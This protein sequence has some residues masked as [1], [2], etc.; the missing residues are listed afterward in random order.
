M[1]PAEEAESLKISIYHVLFLIL[2]QAYQIMPPQLVLPHLIV[3][4]DYSNGTVPKYGCFNRLCPGMQVHTSL[5]RL[6]SKMMSSSLPDVKSFL[7]WALALH[8]A[9]TQYIHHN[10]EDR[11]K[12]EGVKG[13]VKYRTRTKSTSL[14]S[15]TCSLRNSAVPW[16][17]QGAGTPQSPDKAKAI[18]CKHTVAI[19]NKGFS[20]LY[21]SIFLSVTA[22]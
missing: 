10:K 3:N 21:K 2:F 18:P 15:F 17:E 22:V 19:Q 20:L 11:N 1:P 8:Q 14:C 12:S 7:G 5:S 13:T 6:D 9:L 4:A 16:T